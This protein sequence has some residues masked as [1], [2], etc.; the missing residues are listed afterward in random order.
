MVQ[1][2]YCQKCGN[3][4][5]EG[6]V[7]PHCGNCNVSYYRNA[8][9]CASVL[10]IKDGKVLLSRRAK[11]PRKGEYDIIGGFMEEDE[12]PEVAAL[13]EAKEETGL[14]LK[15]IDL[16]GIYNDQYGKDGDHTLN[17]H[18]IADIIGGKMKAQDDV[19][20]LE[21]IAIDKVPTNE[22]FQ[23]TRDGLR[24]L[25]IWYKQNYGKN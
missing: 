15:I 5:D 21:W 14:D 4:I 18:Y 12:L 17:I 25:K 19:E 1:Y 10:P 13:R 7:P 23:N 6:S 2:N 24:D 22:G 11:E 8:K 3:Q 9:P 20:S 16:L